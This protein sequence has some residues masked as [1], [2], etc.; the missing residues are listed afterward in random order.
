VANPEHPR[1]IDA[2]IAIAELYLLVGFPIQSGR[3]RRQLEQVRQRSLSAPQKETADYLSFWIEAAEANL[4]RADELGRMFLDAWPSSPRRPEVLMKMG[5]MHF[6]ERD[7]ARAQATFDELVRTFPDSP[8]SE[9]ALFFSAQSA[10]SSMN[11]KDRDTAI[12]TLGKIIDRGGPLAEEARHQQALAKLADGQPEEAL[13]VLESLLGLRKD[14]SPSLQLAALITKGRAHYA[15]TERNELPENM[16]IAAIGAF[17]QVIEFPNANRSWVNRASLHKGRCLERLGDDNRA[18]E[19]YYDVVNR[20]PD[21]GL[22]GREAPEYTWYDRS[23]FAAIEILRN[24]KDWR[25]AVRLAERLGETNGPR[26]TEAKELANR[27]RLLH[28]LWEE[29]E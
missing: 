29:E 13:A 20:R 10:R 7:F 3:A 28:F 15:L 25:S 24:R 6:A 17:D 22:N 16:L 26:A 12:Q 8:L 19:V 23:G 11:R 9:A 4:S 1:L 27:M 14:L 5:E 21:E 18:L 2:E